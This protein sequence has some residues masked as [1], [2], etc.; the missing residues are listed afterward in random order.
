[1]FPVMND[2]NYWVMKLSEGSKDINRK[3]GYFTPD[4]RKIF[5]N[6]FSE[7]NARIARKYLH[8]KDGVLFYDDKLDISR[9]E[10]HESGPFEQAMIRSFIAIASVQQ[11]RI[12]KLEERNRI[13]AHWWIQ[14]KCHNKC[15]VLF[16]A[17]R[18]CVELLN[19]FDFAPICI[20][21]N[22]KKKAGMQIKNRPVVYAGDFH[23][24][25]EVFILV[26]CEKTAEIELQL[27]NF[28][29]M[30]GNDYILA[31]EWLY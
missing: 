16:G 7:E 5:M 15:L 24:W 2:L 29:L 28:S 8:R 6:Q 3:Q 22:D 17:G 25:S 27:Q 23:R 14:T 31:S 11:S 21:D 13:M 12:N 30:K 9:E 20:V 4:K 1:G 19:A 10:M 18:R 26:T